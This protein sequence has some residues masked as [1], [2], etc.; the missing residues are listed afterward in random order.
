M[1]GIIHHHDNVMFISYSIIAQCGQITNTSLGVAG[2]GL[3]IMINF[4]VGVLDIIIVTWYHIIF[5]SLCDIYIPQ[6]DACKTR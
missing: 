2:R 6:N 3:I 1:V 5:C 4:T